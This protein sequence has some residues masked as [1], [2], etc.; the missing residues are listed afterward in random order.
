MAI[1]SSSGL[2]IAMPH[3]AEQPMHWW[4]VADGAVIDSGCDMELEAA[5]GDAIVALIPIAD[6]PLYTLPHPDLPVKQ[7]EAV[8]AR[9][10]LARALSPTPHAAAHKFEAASETAMQGAVVDAARLTHGLSL[11]KLRG[12]TPDYAIP[13][14]IVARH[15]W[16]ASDAEAVRT[17]VMGETQWASAM[18]VYP[19]DTDLI[20][21]LTPNAAPLQGGEDALAQA[22]AAAFANPAP[23]FLTGAFAP[24]SSGRTIQAGH[25]RML[26]TL[27]LGTLLLTLAIGVASWWRF[28]AAAEAA[29]ERALAAMSKTIGA[30]N[31][32]ASGE[33]ALDARLARE[34]RG[35]AVMSVPLSALY[36][37]MQAAPQVGLRQLRYTPDGTLLATMAAPTSEAANAILL[38]LQQD[39]YKVTATARTDDTGAQVVDVTIRGY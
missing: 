1:A 34:G 38:R 21:L 6:A 20:Q 26:L 3:S 7:A 16:W 29:D 36:Q 27:L 24:I 8:A 9:H 30:Q 14:A 4:R 18:A 37:A 15:M 11:M 17:E 25:W 2:L 12:L 22:M 19:A 28:A 13:A 35:A 23:N 33:G 31:D 32:L 10:L 39:G 5:E